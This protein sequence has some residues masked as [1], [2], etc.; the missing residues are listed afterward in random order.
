LG[1][2]HPKSVFIQDQTPGPTETFINIGSEVELSSVG[3][4][5][6]LGTD[7]IIFL[8][9]YASNDKDVELYFI[10]VESSDSIE[11]FT[12]KFWPPGLA[13]SSSSTTTQNGDNIVSNPQF[14]DVLFNSINGNTFLVT[15]TQATVIAPDWEVL[16]TG[17]GTITVSQIAVTDTGVPGEPAFALQIGTTGVTGSVYLSQTINNSPRILAGEFASGTIVAKPI[18]GGPY[19]LTMNYVPSSGVLTE[20]ATGSCSAGSF[21]EIKGVSLTS[22]PTTN[23]DSGLVGFVAIQI[24]ILLVPRFKYLAYRQSVF[25]IR[26]PSLRIFK[27]PHLDRLTICFITFSQRLITSRYQVIWLDGI[28]L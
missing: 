11:Q 19:T 14:A 16:T 4:T 1:N 24:V 3:T 25:Q 6:Y 12:R 15:G 20:L 13:A 2:D 26:Q 8:Y 21:T 22:I 5:Q 28:F 9:P 27:K 18:G 10:K 17:T 7:T 23:A